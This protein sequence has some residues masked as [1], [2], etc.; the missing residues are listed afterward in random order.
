MAGSYSEEH[1]SAALTTTTYTPTTY[2]YT[3]THIPSLLPYPMALACRY[4]EKHWSTRL[5]TTRKKSKRHLVRCRGGNR[6]RAR[7]RVRAR[8]RG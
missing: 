7:V 6:L 5:T 1:Q 3:P 4:S 8:V 2:P